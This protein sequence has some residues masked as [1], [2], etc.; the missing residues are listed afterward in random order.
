MT[1]LLRQV[2]AACINMPVVALTASL[3][4]ELQGCLNAG[5]TDVITKVRWSKMTPSSP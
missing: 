5:F 4:N 1:P 2:R 3:Q